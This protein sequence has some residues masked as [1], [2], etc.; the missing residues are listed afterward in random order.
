M[1]FFLLIKTFTN[2]ILKKMK[3]FLICAAI[4]VAGVVAWAAS[5]TNVA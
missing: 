5:D 4:A 2:L 1:S 3:K